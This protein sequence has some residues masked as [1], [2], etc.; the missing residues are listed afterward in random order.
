VPSMSDAK[1][2]TRQDFR[3]AVFARDGR[4][5][6]V[7]GA[8]GDLDAHH[9]TD[10]RDMPNGGYVAANGISLCATCHALAETWH[11]SAQQ[12]FEVGYHPDDLYKLIESSW[13]D[14]WEASEKLGDG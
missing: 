11:A 4:R 14:A 3:E 10:R 7:C 12:H 2:K 5:C 1:K 8:T 13:Q 6:R 9:I